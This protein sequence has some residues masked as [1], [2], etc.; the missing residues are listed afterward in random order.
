MKARLYRVP[1]D[2]D[3]HNCAIYVAGH[4]A[5]EAFNNAARLA[6]ANKFR[7]AEPYL[8]GVAEVQGVWTTESN[9]RQAFRLLD[10]ETLH[11]AWKAHLGDERT[12]GKDLEDE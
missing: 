4:S 12:R 5:L 8:G 11:E 9:G 1:I 3:P 6:A 10:A 2:G 7:K